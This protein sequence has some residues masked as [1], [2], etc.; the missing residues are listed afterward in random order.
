MLNRSRNGRIVFQILLLLLL[1]VILIA[2][3][4]RRGPA[5]AEDQGPPWVIAVDAFPKHTFVLPVDI[6]HAGDS[7]LFVVEQAGVIKVLDGRGP[8]ATNKLFMDIS[9]RVTSSAE[10][11]LLGLAFHPDYQQNGYFFVNYTRTKGDNWETVISR[12]QVT[13]DP[14]TADP[15]SELTLLQISQPHSNHN[16]G[17]L[18]FGPD[19]KLYISLGDGGSSGDPDNRAQDGGDLLG[20]MLRIDV[21][22]PAAGKNYGIPADNP[23][24]GQPT[25]DEI[26]AIGLRNPWRFSFD[27]LTGD[28]YIGDVGQ[29]LWEE[30]NF[31]PAASSGGQNYGWRLKEGNHCFMPEQNCD[32]GGLTDPIYEYGHNEGCSV[33]GGAVYRGPSMPSLQGYYLYADY[34]TG[35]I[36]TLHRDGQGVWQNEP[37]TK[38]GKY[39]STFGEDNSGELYLAQHGQGK[40]YRLVEQ[41]GS[42]FLPFLG[43]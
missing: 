15:T 32:P 31:Q 29:Y 24:V 42:I 28:L 3:G 35:V 1:I 2:V 11:G 30:I 16:G 6:T 22:K 19:G 7:R 27:R 20:K 4:P 34:C 25:L 9:D 17:G 38:I 40:I 13:A 5:I 21:D 14:D 18:Q 8:S 10:L 43:S 12:F 26:W 33:T 37:L 41:H 39:V 36:S 23:F